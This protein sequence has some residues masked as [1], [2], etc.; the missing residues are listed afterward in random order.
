MN[1]NFT[2]NSLA[3]RFLHPK[4]TLSVVLLATSLVLTLD[5]L[6]FKSGGSLLSL[7]AILITIYFFFVSIFYADKISKKTDEN[8]FNSN[9]YANMLGDT[10][11]LGNNLLIIFSDNEDL[12]SKE[13]EIDKLRSEFFR[14]FK[15]AWDLIEEDYIKE[16]YIQKL[17]PFLGLLSEDIS[18][19]SYSMI[20][21][22]KRSILIHR[23]GSLIA[24]IYQLKLYEHHSL[25]WTWDVFYKDDFIQYPIYFYENFC[26]QFKN[27]KDF[28]HKEELNN[29]YNDLIRDLDWCIG[30]IPDLKTRFKYYQ[31]FKNYTI[32][33]TLS[34]LNNYE[35]LLFPDDLKTII[36]DANSIRI[37]KEGIE[38]RKER[39]VLCVRS[40]DKTEFINGSLHTIKN[41]VEL[42]N[43]RFYMHKGCYLI[44]FENN[45]SEFGSLELLRE[46]TN[47]LSSLKNNMD[48]L[49]AAKDFGDTVSFS[50]RDYKFNEEEM[51]HDSNKVSIY[52]FVRS[53]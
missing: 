51:L 29:S 5:F 39:T 4:T 12:T 41:P 45:S 42:I 31:K 34:N 30:N 52:E 20:P 44:V 40:S 27:S 1:F 33:E 6:Y 7:H 47:C 35:V 2:L 21:K 24:S 48:R 16:A 22:E 13:R 18:L 3:E 14:S 25:D 37:F 50:M 53:L 8:I 10:I 36:H 9:L 32:A 11:S 28:T 38:N 15:V 26:S 46:F 49:I 17:L 43:I 19:K 23:F